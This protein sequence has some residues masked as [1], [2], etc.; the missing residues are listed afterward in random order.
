MLKSLAHLGGPDVANLRSCSEPKLEQAAPTSA[1][2]LAR[3]KNSNE[4]GRLCLELSGETQAEAARGTTLFQ[5]KR[6]A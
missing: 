4:T 1:C 6:Q 5:K 2:K 3:P